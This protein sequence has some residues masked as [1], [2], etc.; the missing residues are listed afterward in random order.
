MS[1]TTLGE[2]PPGSIFETKEGIKAVKSEY[3]YSNEP[4]SQCQCVL[5]ESGE[6]AHFPEK[7][8]TAVRKIDPVGNI[9]E[10]SSVFLSRDEEIWDGIVGALWKLCTGD[11]ADARKRANDFIV[12]IVTKI[13]WLQSRE[14]KT[15]EAAVAMRLALES[16]LYNPHCATNVA[17]GTHVGSGLCKTCSDQYFSGQ[18]AVAKIAKLGVV[19]D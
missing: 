3:Y 2:L 13:R 9:L 12:E 16:Y 1:W 8:K 11:T 10:V 17:N 19:D 15:R 14:Q 7:N 4:Y 6:Y 5:L 18:D